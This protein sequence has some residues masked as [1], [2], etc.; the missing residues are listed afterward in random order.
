M[1]HPIILELEREGAK[2]DVPPFG[3][4]DT[5]KVQLRVTEG[6]KERVQTFQGTVLRRYGRA[7]RER[8]TVRRISHAVGVERTFFVHSPLIE[9]IELTRKGKVRRARLYF[10]RKKVGRAAKIEEVR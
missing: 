7:I 10:L 4:G 9:R 8:F 5:V 6:G 1:T 3:P 2:K